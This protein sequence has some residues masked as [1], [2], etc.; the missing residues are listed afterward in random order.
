MGNNISS[1]TKGTQPNLSPIQRQLIE[2][3][4]SSV[5]PC[6]KDALWA[7]LKNTDGR[8]AIQ[9]LASLLA[10]Q[11]QNQN[12]PLTPEDHKRM[13]RNRARALA[14]RTSNLKHLHYVQHREHNRRLH[15]ES[16][17]S[18]TNANNH[19]PPAPNT[20][21]GGPFAIGFTPHPSP[22][23]Q[24]QNLKDPPEKKA[25][26]QTT[27]PAT[28]PFAVT[29]TKRATPARN[30]YITRSQPKAERREEM[31][32]FALAKAIEE[33]EDVAAVNILENFE[34]AQALQSLYA[35]ATNVHVVQEQ[36]ARG[37]VHTHQLINVETVEADSDDDQDDE[38]K[39]APPLKSA[40]DGDYGEGFDENGY[41]V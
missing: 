4:L 30:P 6:L 28:R 39:D 16:T 14:I 8:E 23:Q 24:V 9:Y 38:E 37:S 41:A 3:L 10:N 27:I 19:T 21:A 2:V 7:V 25:M 35:T 40:W 15:E 26:K 36:Q 1:R 17:S 22:S 18:S 32:D 5:D 31:N 33:E 12:Q 13:Q 20:G 34:A 11:N 29:P